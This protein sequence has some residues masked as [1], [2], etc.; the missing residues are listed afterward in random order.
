MVNHPFTF[1][2]NNR[3]IIIVSGLPRSGT[4]LMMKMLESGGLEVLV[5]HLRKADE[6]N[7]NGYYEYEKVKTLDAGNVD[8]LPEAVG[9]VVKI[10]AT[11]IPYLPESYNYS[12]IFMQRV[13][14]EILAS[15]LKMLS[16]LGKD[17]DAVDVSL[18]TGIYEKHLKAVNNWVENHAN[19][20]RLD[21]QHHDL[22]LDPMPQILRINEF[23]GRN[24]DSESMQRAVD[25]KL[26]RQRKA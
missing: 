24:L 19:V 4:S 10:I 6:D 18:M 17:P 11:L 8:W 15:Q 20:R 26:Y 25:P 16:N 2:D 5:D 7:P 12:I 3:T 13:L 23:L 9:K 22:I 1:L 14:P 21:V